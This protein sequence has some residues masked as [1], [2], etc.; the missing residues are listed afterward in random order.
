M[1]PHD[2]IDRTRAD[3]STTRGARRLEGFAWPLPQIQAELDAIDDAEWKPLPRG[4]AWTSIQ[5]IEADGRGGERRHRLLDTCPAIHALAASFNAKIMGLTL[6]RLAPGGGVHEH[7]DISGGLPMGVIRLHVPLRT[8]PGVQFVVDDVRV[9]MREGQTWQLDTT[10]RHRVANLGSTHR[11][12]LIVDLAL[13]NALRELLPKP[14]LRDHL[15][16]VEF[17]AVCV[18]KGL[19]LAVTRPRELA[20]RALRFARLRLLGQSVMTF[21]EQPTAQAPDP[22][23][24]N[25]AKIPRPKAAPDYFA[26]PECRCAKLELVDDLALRPSVPWAGC[27]GLRCHDCARE[28]PW[29]A[30]V[31]VLWSDELA[32]LIAAGD[33]QPNTHAA[34]EPRAVKQANYAIYQQVS[35]AYGEH[36]DAS[37]DYV[38]QLLLLKAHAREAITTAT[39]NEQ[40]SRVLVDVGCASGFSLD[41]GSAGFDER[42]GVDISLAN[43]EQVAARGHVAVLADAER[44][45]FAA[46]S[47]DLLT[48]FA[49]MHHF[50]S[51]EAFLRSASASLRSGG[52][53][54][55]AADPSADNM[56]MGPLARAA[57]QL[58]KPVYRQ[59]ARL[60]PRFYLHANART[61]A[62]ND[63]AEHHRTSGGFE[64]AQLQAMLQAAGLDA[65]ELFHGVDRRGRQRWGKP[66]WQEFVLKSLSGRNPLLRRNFVALSSISVKPPRRA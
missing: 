31:W 10:Y 65:P 2:W 18:G 26:C 34:P 19:Q 35:E 9:I 44:L 25:L 51:C 1:Q 63:L 43:L 36:A 38:D 41:V 61:Q 53:L 33:I 52:V 54:L 59:L 22:S 6:A 15:H 40:R 60:S 13:T 50:P 32:A 7:R 55:T 66:S 8:N 64:P 56:Y 28:F 57:W 21:E 62:L 24:P 5:L 29:V 42:V 4:R 49:A 58:R 23:G 17:A 46:G 39:D 11:V 12:H 30:G 47:I 37:V 48:C 14:D 3:S 45:P 27:V 16:R 20:D